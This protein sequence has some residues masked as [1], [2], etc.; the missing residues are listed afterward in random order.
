MILGVFLHSAVAYMH[1]PMPGLL[2]PISA[3][4]SGWGFDAVLW[5]IHGF[6]I[7]VF[8][9]VAGFFAGLLCDLKGPQYY[10]WQRLTRIAV[11][12][13][14]AIVVILP[15]VYFLWG[16][17]LLEQGR[18]TWT[19]I[20]HRSFA[21]PQIHYGVFG[22]GHLWFL[23]YLLIYSLIYYVFRIGFPA[24]FRGPN[25]LA[26]L[27]H[28]TWPVFLIGVTFPMLWLHP[29]IYLDFQNRWLPESWEFVYYGL[30]FIAGTLM[31][32]VYNQLNRFIHLGP[33]L[34]L[35]S[36][37]VFSFQF[38]LIKKSLSGD[39]VLLETGWLFA[40]LTALYSWL[41][42]WG[43]LGLCLKVLD[44]PSRRMRFLSDSAY[45]IYLVHLPL[46]VFIQLELEYFQNYAGFAILPVVGYTITVSGTLLISLLSYRY[47]VRY[48]TIGK[49]L[50]GPK[51]KPID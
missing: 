50:H 37:A 3:P 21:N 26:F 1:E 32:R 16:L 48:R 43:F 29:D 8:F 14:V 4:S 20:Q 45:W 19:E 39:P 41:A 49:W 7:P 27:N 42:V 18:L 31:Y 30:Y 11:P 40:L 46:V 51:V 44:R 22:L 25:R 13:S 38:S 34:V 47:L 23:Q 15:I 33:V 9:L 5:Y 36:L 12:L 24:R 10:L 28:W 17:G 2:W 6:R 35:A